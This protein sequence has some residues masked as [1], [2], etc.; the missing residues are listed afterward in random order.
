MA[1]G[2][3]MLFVTALI[4]GAAF[5]AQKLGMDHVGPFAFTLY[6]NILAVAFLMIVMAVRNL[7]GHGSF[8]RAETRNAVVGGVYCGVALF[9]AMVAQQLG[10][11][12]TSPGVCAF[13]TANYVLAV[14]LL[15]LMLGRCPRWFV[16]PGVAAAVGGTYLICVTGGEVASV[17]RGELLSLACA[18]LFALQIIVA[19]KW[20]RRSDVLL[21]SIV[22]FA[23]VG[24]LSTPFLMLPSERVML[25]WG[26]IRM[27]VWAIL[28][29][30][31]MSSGIAYTLQNFGQRRVPAALASLVMSLESVFGAL[32]GWLFLGDALGTRQLLGCVCVFAA[33]VFTQLM[34]SRNQGQ[35]TGQ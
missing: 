17:G 8:S 13:L 14:P 34:E 4:W 9:A 1:I 10:I 12:H 21:L 7:S 29:C 28:F 25:G 15:G 24:V 2:L 18:F 11:V 6:R 22:Q 3:L 20:V 5:L 31:V 23:T 16:W 32:F 33:V 27:G 26:N 35:V 19:E 30:G